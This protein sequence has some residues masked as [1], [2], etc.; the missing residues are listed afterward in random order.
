MPAFA[1]NEFVFPNLVDDYSIKCVYLIIYLITQ[2]PGI[3]S[4]EGTHGI[5]E[6]ITRQTHKK[7]KR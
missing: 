6:G 5:L 3:T 2:K 1:C 7:G 4:S